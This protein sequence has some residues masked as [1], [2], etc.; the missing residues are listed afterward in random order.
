MGLTAAKAGGEKSG[1]AVGAIGG[2]LINDYFIR[3]GVSEGKKGYG[4]AIGTLEAGKQEGLSYLMP[5]M[6]IGKQSISPLSQLL[7]GKSY[8]A[9]TGQFSDVAPENRLSAFYQSPDYQFRLDQ[10]QKALE[11]SQAARGGL[12]TGRALQESQQLGQNLASSEYGNY[13][14]RLFGLAG[15][16]QS[17]AGQG[18]NIAGNVASQIGTAQIGIGNLGLQ[19]NI[20]RGQNWADTAGSL[21]GMFGGGGR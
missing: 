15:M 12:L 21:G 6:D 11:Y 4:K 5:Y 19:G 9:E 3:R 16:G 8:D 17:S 18:A 10:G 14:Q 13:L 7:L 20:A 2:G 1:G